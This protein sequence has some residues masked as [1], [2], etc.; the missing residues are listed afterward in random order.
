MLE[1]VLA[2][3]K[4]LINPLLRGVGVCDT[5]SKGKNIIVELRVLRGEKNM[6]TQKKK[7]EPAS[8]A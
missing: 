2:K 1:V 7:R 5:D 8:V 4:E 6:N 3:L